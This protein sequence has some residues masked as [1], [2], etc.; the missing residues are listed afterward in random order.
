MR[1]VHW[2]TL[3]QKRA[4]SEQHSRDL[5]RV[6]T[7]ACARRYWGFCTLIKNCPP[8]PR[9]NLHGQVEPESDETRSNH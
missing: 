7:V 6:Y 8:F 9:L 3:L 1:A 4:L 2:P 5:C